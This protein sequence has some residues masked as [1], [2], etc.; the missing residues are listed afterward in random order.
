[1]HP[2]PV[3]IIT[4]HCNGND[5]GH[6]SQNMQYVSFL[7]DRNNSDDSSNGRSQAIIFCQQCLT[8]TDPYDPMSLLPHQQ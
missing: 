4:D 8:A 6:H 5:A 3:Q 2:T 1:M 7:K